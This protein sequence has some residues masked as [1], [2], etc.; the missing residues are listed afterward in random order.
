MFS[1]VILDSLWWSW[2]RRYRQVR[3]GEKEVIMKHTPE[4]FLV[5]EEGSHSSTVYG[6][7]QQLCLGLSSMS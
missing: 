5:L 4:W 2:S 1:S 6:R 7:W 3:F